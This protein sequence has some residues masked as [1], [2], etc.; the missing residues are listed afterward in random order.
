MSTLSI[1][2]PTLPERYDLLKRLQ[3][4]LIPQV[5]KYSGRVVILYNDVGRSVSTGEKRNRLMEQVNT[6][7][8]VYVDDDDL[9]SRDYVSSIMKAIDQNPDCVTFNGW[10]TTNG[11]NSKD[12]VIKLG[13]KYEERNGIYYRFPNHIAPMKTELV[14]HVKFPHITTGEDFSWAKII[15]DRKLLKTSI[16][17]EDRLYHYCYISNKPPYGSGNRKVHPVR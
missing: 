3:H 17:I 9:L 5:E 2:I 10:M 6:T 7:Y 4:I 12:F 16:H 15:H 13:E 11:Y 14:R 8:H 1:L